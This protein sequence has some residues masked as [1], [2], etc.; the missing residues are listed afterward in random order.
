MNS[1]IRLAVGFVFIPMTLFIAGAQAQ[2]REVNSQEQSWFSINSSIRLNN[3]FGIVADVHVR[4][5]EFLAREGFYFARLGTSYWIKENLTATAGYAHMW[6]APAKKGW[7]YHAEEHR[8]YQQLQLGS[9][10]GK[11]SL[12]QRF[13]SEQRWQEKVVDDR[14][15]S[16][17]KF[18]NRVRYLLSV[19]VP[20]F[21]DPQL[22]KLVIA[23]ELAVQF[24]RE[25][26][27]NTFDQNRIFL[28]I[29]QQVSQSLAFDFGYMQVYQQKASGYQ[30]DKNHTLRWFFYY[31]P[32]LRHKQKQS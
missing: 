32:H 15:T 14:F 28:G 9:H 27:Y 12:L 23:D 3:K 31:T 30:Y 11:V 16:K 26:L 8:V 20:L 13:R 21:K 2:A 5:N 4:R 7:Q 6:M 10:V 29:R 22:P 18:T 17:Y 19:T 25:I 24:G 1:N